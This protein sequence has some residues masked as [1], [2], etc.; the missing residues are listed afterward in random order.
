M[1]KIFFF[2]YNFYY[3]N[4]NPDPRMDPIPQVSTL[5]AFGIAFWIIFF[6]R[7]FSYFLRY[8]VGLLT[9]S[10]VAGCIG[11]ICGGLVHT[12]YLDMNRTTK[13]YRKYKSSLTLKKN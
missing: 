11:L 9:H 3:K 1:N 12:Y 2:L 5:F 4:G 13:L 8:K 10:I 6:D 7:L